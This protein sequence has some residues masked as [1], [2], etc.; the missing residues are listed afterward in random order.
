MCRYWRCRYRRYVRTCGRRL[1]CSHEPRPM[2]KAMVTQHWPAHMGCMSSIHAHA[3]PALRLDLCRGSS[4]CGMSPFLC[5]G[6][7]SD[8]P[9]LALPGCHPSACS[10]RRQHNVHPARAGVAP[11]P[12][13]SNQH[14]PHPP[15]RH[16]QPRTWRGRPRLQWCEAA[17]VRTFLRA[18]PSVP[19]PRCIAVARPGG[20][21]Q[22]HATCSPPQQV[23][24]LK[25]GHRAIAAVAGVRRRRAAALLLLL[26]RGPLGITKCS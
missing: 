4:L 8:N 12:T 26:L 7:S 2:T 1:R 24:D 11:P 17:A 15:R 20:D 16:T 18:G 6:S 13:S 22:L 23:L 19:G 3:V 14:T 25:H 21:I 5:P 10:S 9:H